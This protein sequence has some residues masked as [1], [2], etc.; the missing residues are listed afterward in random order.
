MGPPGECV[1]NY[2]RVRDRTPKD[3]K[4]HGL[5]T[6]IEATGDREHPAERQEES[7]ECGATSTKG[8]RSFRMEKLVIGEGN[9]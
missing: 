6:G 7:Q 9:G 3:S 4:M 1:Q 5:G 2:D 8:A